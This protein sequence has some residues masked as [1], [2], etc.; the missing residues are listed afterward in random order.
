[1][2][3]ENKKRIW[4]RLD[5]AAK[6]FPASMRPNWSNVFRLSVSFH[7]MIDPVALSRAASRAAKRFP[8]VCVRLGT[9]L[10]WYYLE[11]SKQ[12]PKPRKEGCQPLLPMRKKEMH[13][14]ALRVVY[15]ENRLAV[16]FF[17]ALTDGSGA[18]IFLKTLAAMYLE[19]RYG[20]SCYDGEGVLFPD[21]KPD[22][23]E[24]EDAF[25]RYAG[26]TAA[27][28]EM[29][30][31]FRLT[32]KPEPDGF[33][34]VTCGTVSCAQI[35]RAAKEK[36]VSL[37]TY[38]AAA[39]CYC[40]EQI[41]K[42]RVAA[43]KEKAVRIQ[44]PV[45]LRKC[46]PSRT[47]RNFVAVYNVG[48]EKG[49]TDADFDELLSRIHHQMALYN[50]PRNLRAIFTANVNS[51]KGMAIRLVPLF[52]KNIVMRAVFDRVGESLACLC[53]SNLGAVKLPEKM[54]EYVTGFDFIIG[55]QAKAPYNCGVVSYG[56]RLR[57]HMV[58]NTVEPELEK[59]FF[60]FLTRQGLD[61]TL[62][63]NG[64]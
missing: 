29:S 33:L 19:E 43:H 34:H 6:I 49:E 9:G 1:M 62:E 16:E 25:L 64:R 10:F 26:P 63:S 61:V 41:Q 17:H 22:A 44:I 50:T 21:D 53:L 11:E 42:R 60:T 4:L 55:P 8:S 40:L 35:L 45:N 52:L 3:I 2:K 23:E 7:E 28:R 47:L 51:E 36:G 38:L 57:I 15:Y 12:A 20:V 31:A 14:L 58:R 59:E 46:F 54:T 56:D 27:K 5:N 32:G 37:T 18:M 30:Y 24:L 39:L 48:V 13:R